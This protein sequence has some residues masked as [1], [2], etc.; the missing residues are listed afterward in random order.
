MTSFEEDQWLRLWF[1]GGEPNP[2]YRKVSRDDRHERPA[3]Y[4]DMISDMWRVLG[5]VLSKRA[6][7]V[8]RLG[9]KNLGADEIARGLLGT[10]IFS[11][12]KVHLIDEYEVSEIK[13]RQ[14]DSFRPGSKGCRIEV[15]C[16]FR[17]E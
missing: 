4:W 6:H 11:Q 17:M 16:H 7:V 14:T 5:R 15:D 13:R 2:T 10:S 8:V 1:L 12:R 9:G 3:A